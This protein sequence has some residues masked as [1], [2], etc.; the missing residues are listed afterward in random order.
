MLADLVSSAT[1][2][3]NDSHGDIIGAIRASFDNALA[4]DVTVGN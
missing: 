1:M 2:S 4:I 3:L